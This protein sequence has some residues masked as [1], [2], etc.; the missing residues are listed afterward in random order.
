MIF[1]YIFRFSENEFLFN[2]DCG[3]RIVDLTLFKRSECLTNVST[4]LCA[5]YKKAPRGT[6]GVFSNIYLIL[7]NIIIFYFNILIK[8]SLI[9]NLLFMFVLIL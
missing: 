9:Y 5:G 2:T 7:F 4:L 1:I 6:C 3:L 8:F